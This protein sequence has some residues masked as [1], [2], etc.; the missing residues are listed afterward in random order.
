MPRRERMRKTPPK[1]VEM[2]IMQVVSHIVSE[3]FEV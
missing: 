1:I 2:A 3:E